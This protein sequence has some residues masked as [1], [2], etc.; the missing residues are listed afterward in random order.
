MGNKYTVEL[1]DENNNVYNLDNKE[2]TFTFSENGYYN[3]TIDGVNKTC[4]CLKCEGIK[5]NKD[6]TLEY[7]R[8]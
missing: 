3:F 7:I 1:K 4:Y 2:Y 8:K 6:G 5:H